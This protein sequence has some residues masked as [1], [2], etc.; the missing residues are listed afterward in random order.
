MEKCLNNYPWRLTGWMPFVWQWAPR[1]AEGND[2]QACIRGVEGIVPGSVQLA[3]RKAGLLPDW[4]VGFQA[5]DCEWVENRH[6]MYSTDIE[7]PDEPCEVVIE[8]PDAAG[9]VLLDGQIVGEF[10]GAHRTH[11]VQ[12][13]QKSGRHLL[14]IVL[15][16][17]PDW[18][19]QIGWTSR[20][21]MTK[22]RFYYQWDWCP[23]I[24][25]AGIAG[26]V[27]LRTVS[28]PRLELVGCDTTADSLT[29][30]LR[31]RNLP[32]SQTV[33]IEILDGD[34]VVW[35]SM[36][37]PLSSLECGKTFTVKGMQLW[38]PN[39]CGEAKLY[40]LR[41]FA[42][43]AD[44]LF[45]R[46][47]FRTIRRDAAPNA[48]ADASPWVYSVNGKPLFLQGVNWTPVLP[49]Y[50]DVDEMRYRKLIE[51]YKTM[52][53]NILRVWGGAS[54]ECNFFYDLCD[55]AGILVW[56]E[57][58]LSSSG[59]DNIPPDNPEV[60]KEARLIAEEYVERLSFHPSLAIW[61]GGNELFWEQHHVCDGTEPV[62]AVLK[63]VVTELDGGRVWLPASSSGASENADAKDYGKGIHHDVHGPWQ[64]IGRLEDNW[65]PYWDGDDALF[66]SEV[67]APG[68][69][70][71]EIIRKYAGKEDVMP[72][73]EAPIWS[74]PTT[75]WR[76][77]HV[78]KAENDGRA[79]ESV[80]EYVAWSQKRQAEALKYAILSCKRRFPSCGG[81]IIWMGHDCFPCPANTSLIDFDL[82][83][84]PAAKAVAAAFRS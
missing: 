41:L 38:Q 5:R 18:L 26:N 81:I 45:R 12:L 74:N 63:E 43:G 15:A 33:D 47:G 19:G 16:L 40:T 30:R 37:E 11:C 59:I 58:P 68:A 39:G 32:S 78:F 48:P 35:K 52:G 1:G 10:A 24:V 50:A 8:R 17:P 56:Q 22:P 62:L 64:P 69:A 46:I 2:H 4:N 60:L 75:W 71:A 84:K 7:L 54:R 6:W 79:A 42:D 3:L 55:E 13:P 20:I 28:E 25:Q 65:K 23:R 77:E 51:R 53:V 73:G 76:E 80:E 57:F 82:N 66:R 49:N 29:I 27:F 31:V 83:D 70:S 61:C 14:E 36:D 44:P 67:G 72:V 21:G 9:W 34:T